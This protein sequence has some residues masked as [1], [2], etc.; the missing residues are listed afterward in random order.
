MPTIQAGMSVTS[1]GPIGFDVA[2]RSMARPQLWL[3]GVL[4]PR[5]GLDA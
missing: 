4:V 3:L 2:F 5:I 1:V